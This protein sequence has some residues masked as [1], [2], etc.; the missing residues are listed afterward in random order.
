[1]I[2]T[3]TRLVYIRVCGIDVRVF[4]VIWMGLVA[5]E[6]DCLQ[7][8]QLLCPRCLCS[9]R[10]PPRCYTK[11][12]HGYH[13]TEEMADGL[14]MN[15]RQTKRELTIRDEET[16]RL[17]STVVHLENTLAQR[18][19]E[20]RDTVRALSVLSA[21]IWYIGYAGDDS[22]NYGATLGELFRR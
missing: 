18:E 10:Q 14:I 8:T 2:N 7:C 19:R 1:M 5:N 16:R 3:R 17:R 12:S 11:Q 13:T 9:C 6:S 15:L 21:C 4:V 22:H 20:F